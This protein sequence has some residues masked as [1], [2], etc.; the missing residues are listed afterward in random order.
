MR[1]TKLENVFPKNKT[2]TIYMRFLESPKGDI[3]STYMREMKRNWEA[4]KNVL[5][6]P[7]IKILNKIKRELQ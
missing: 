6:T 4:S 1:N 7:Y 2:Q 3:E 5:E